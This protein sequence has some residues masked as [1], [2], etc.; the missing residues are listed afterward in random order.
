MSGPNAEQ[1]VPTPPNRITTDDRTDRVVNPTPVELRLGDPT[2]GRYVLLSD[3][4]MFAHQYAARIGR[5]C[6]PVRDDPQSARADWHDVAQTLRTAAVEALAPPVHEPDAR[7]LAR[8][9]DAVREQL[10]RGA[11]A[12]TDQPGAYGVLA[13]RIARAA[14]AA[15][16]DHVEPLSP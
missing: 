4:L 15:A 7:A 12:L 3:A 2:L 1:P 9:S 16:R 6:P 5:A 14:L 8:A 13:D 11:H 10:M